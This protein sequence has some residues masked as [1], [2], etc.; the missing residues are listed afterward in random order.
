MRRRLFGVAAAAAC[1]AGVPAGFA[2]GQAL[3]D[4]PMPPAGPHEAAV[5]CPEANALFRSRGIEADFFVPD[6]PT[7]AQL[8]AIKGDLSQDPVFVEACEAEKARGELTD[9]CKGLL[10]AQEDMARVRRAYR[11]AEVSE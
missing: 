1:I 10:E 9:G 8:E 3:T 2:V 11:A 7:K 4:K 6:C 5:A